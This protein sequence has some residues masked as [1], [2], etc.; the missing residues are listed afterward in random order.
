MQ[1]TQRVTVSLRQQQGYNFQVDWG[2]ANAPPGTVDEPPPIGG[3]AGPNAA[4]LV[5]AAVAHCLASSLLFC[6]EKSHVAGTTISASVEAEIQRNDK[7]RWR[8]AHLTVTLDPKVPAGTREQLSR[9]R[10]IFED[11]CIVT[12][13]IRHGI[14]VDVKWVENPVG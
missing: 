11:Y 1:L 13:S 5:A 10:E 14:P 2:L 9:C 8:L 12:E 6:L 3:G 4:R 7:G